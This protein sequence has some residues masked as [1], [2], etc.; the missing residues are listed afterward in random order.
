ML[1]IILKILY[2]YIIRGILKKEISKLDWL[3]HF[4]D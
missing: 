4:Y 3:M 2:E 1:K